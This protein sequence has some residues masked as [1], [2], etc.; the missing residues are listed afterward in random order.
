MKEP[1]YNLGEEIF[2]R[3]FLGIYVV[4]MGIRFISLTSSGRHVDVTSVDSD[5]DQ[6]MDGHGS[7]E[8]EEEE[9]EIL[10]WAQV[11]D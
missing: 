10:Q 3:G 2:G 1:R 11:N 5:C 8:E 6:N 4:T 7:E 9:T